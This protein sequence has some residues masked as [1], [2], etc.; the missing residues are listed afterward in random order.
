MWRDVIF[1]VEASQSC[2]VSTGTENLGS[3]TATMALLGRFKTN[4]A[5]KTCFCKAFETF[6]LLKDKG[7]HKQI[8]SIY[9][10]LFSSTACSILLVSSHM[11]K[12]RIYCSW[13]SWNGKIIWDSRIFFSFIHVCTDLHQKENSSNMPLFLY[14]LL[15]LIMGIHAATEIQPCL[16]NLHLFHNG[17]CR[18]LGFGIRYF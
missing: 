1:V 10:R 9:S 15:P 18:Y 17:K 4:S 7:N 11:G 8:P 2:I 5:A 13:S 12:T 6:Q 14:W 3:S 16:Y